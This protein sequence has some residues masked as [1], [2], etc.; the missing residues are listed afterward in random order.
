[1]IFSAA[2]FCNLFKAEVTSGDRTSL[3]NQVAFPLPVKIIP[4]PQMGGRAPPTSLMQLALDIDFMNEDQNQYKYV[5]YFTT[6]FYIDSVYPNFQK[7]LL[8]FLGLP[9]AAGDV[10]LSVNPFMMK[11]SKEAAVILRSS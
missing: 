11:H 3:Q 2:L 6:D 1:M 4:S 5:P 9:D 10:M 7:L 8:E